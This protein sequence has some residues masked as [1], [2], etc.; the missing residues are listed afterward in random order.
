MNGRRKFLAGLVSCAALAPGLASAAY[1]CGP[2]NM[3]GVMPCNAGIPSEIAAVIAE[4]PQYAS[5]WC[6]AASM[7]M[8]FDYYGYDVPQAQIVS[9]VYGRTVNLPAVDS[10][11]IQALSRPWVDR[12]GRAFD[13]RCDV[14]L[15]AQH[16]FSRRDLKQKATTY[17]AEGRPLIIGTIGHAMLLTGVNYWTTTYDA[18]AGDVTAASVRDPWPG[19]GKRVLSAQEW[20][21][22]RF[23]VAP[24]VG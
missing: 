20:Y 8:V 10:T 3:N 18:N 22:T 1:R 12:A 2:P 21:S 17:L 9:E 13:C 23:L 5:Q 24:I 7:E 11:I 4:D 19:R 14:L 15:S 6:W 16:G